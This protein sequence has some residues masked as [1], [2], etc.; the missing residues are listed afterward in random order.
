MIV[1]FLKAKKVGLFQPDSFVGKL[2]LRKLLQQGLPV[3]CFASK[4]RLE[5]L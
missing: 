4:K 5:S 1:D 3:T 2:I